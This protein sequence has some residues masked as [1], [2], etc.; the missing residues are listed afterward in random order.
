MQSPYEIGHPLTAKQIRQLPV[1]A[2]HFVGRGLTENY[3]FLLQINRG[4]EGDAAR[5]S[6]ERIAAGVEKGSIEAV[7]EG[8]SENEISLHL[9][10]PEAYMSGIITFAGDNSGS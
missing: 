6:L 2:C 5:E 7:V 4:D 9:Q 3:R 8:I 1:S 10:G